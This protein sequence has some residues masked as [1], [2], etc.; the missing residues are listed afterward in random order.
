MIKKITVE[1]FRGFFK[2]EAKFAIPN[3]KNG[4]GL[5][6]I[7]GP[8]NAGKTSILEALL[9]NRHR[10][11][12]D[13]E[14]HKKHPPKIVHFN[15][16]GKTI[17]YE[18]TNGSSINTTERE[19]SFNPEFI[20]AG[21]RLD[22]NFATSQ[23]NA[24]TFSQN[25]N[26]LNARGNNSG[27]VVGVLTGLSRISGGK[28]ALTSLM[29]E[30]VPDFSDWT[31]DKN[32]QGNYIKYVIGNEEHQGQFL[33][34]GI[35][36]LFRIFIH[37][38]NNNPKTRTLIIDEPELS[39]H[40]A[41]QKGLARKLSDFSKDNQVIIC[42][43]SPYFVNWDDLRNGAQ[44]IRLN[45][46][47]GQCFV[48]SLRREEIEKLIS[49][50]EN[51][52]MKPQLL[53]VAAKEIFFSDKILFVEGQEDVALIRKWLKDNDKQVIFDIFGYGVGGC[54]N[55]RI[56]AEMATQL[57]LKK[58]AVLSDGD[59]KAKNSIKDLPEGVKSFSLPT[60]DIRD[61]EEKK[62]ECG[63]VV[64]TKGKKGIFERQG[65]GK[66]KVKEKYEDE[67]KNLMSEIL[68]YFA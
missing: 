17:V 25:S 6:I 53:D 3:G 49:L 54:D 21:R 43:H 27:D 4:S 68:S 32:D 47:N 23:V 2:E 9:V 28:E 51:D 31:I 7:V 35:I 45:K 5:T 8:N 33:G 62:C 10:Q 55:F 29:R 19:F 14:R 39:L 63:K 61:K 41:A 13:S 56:F 59:N 60:D 44:L 42:T 57:D 18:G 37:F 16:E 67:F 46:K 24:P 40:P 65:G 50:K 64:I 34:D 22:S 26:T 52:W 15:K 11:F 36:S 66:Y 1:N 48:N 30:I 58:V 12:R 20:N 38:V